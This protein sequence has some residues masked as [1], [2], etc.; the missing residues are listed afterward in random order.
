MPAAL[1]TTTLMLVLGQAPLDPNAGLQPGD[2]PAAAYPAPAYGPG[3]APGP[4]YGAG[5]GYGAG[6]TFGAGIGPGYGGAYGGSC[7]TNEYGAYG[8]SGAPNTLNN[9]YGNYRL[10]PGMAG[11]PTQD[12]AYPPYDAIEPWVHG[13]W[14]ELPAYGGHAYFRPYNYRHVY[15]QSE[16]AASWGT[17]AV[18]PYSQEYFRRPREQGIYEQR[19]SSAARTNPSSAVAYRQQPRA[20]QNSEV[21]S[22]TGGVRPQ[23][24]QQQ[25]PV[26]SNRQ[27]VSGP[28]LFKSRN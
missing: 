21:I 12:Y 14:Q 23:Q 26:S 16:V 3:Y 2:Y 7:A 10:T 19:Q 17:S 13:H 20:P 1:L 8:Y 28:S 5:A 11:T 4:T 22:R 15:I 24:P 25:P 27:A 6:Q 18:L 9:A